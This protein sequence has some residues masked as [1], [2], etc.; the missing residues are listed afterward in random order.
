ME[1]AV[2]TKKAVKTTTDT[3]RCLGY[4]RVS[5]LDQRETGLSVDVQQSMILE[6][7]GEMGGDL[8]EDV[9]IDD[10][11]SGTNMNRPGLTALLAR[12]SECDIDYLIFQDSSRLSRD[13][14]DY[15]TI[16]TVLNKYKIE[17]IALTGISS[18]DDDPYSKFFDEILASVNALHPR[19]SGYKAK[20][21]QVEK[22]KS[23]WYPSWA[24]IGYKNIKNP[25]PTSRYDQKIIALD[26]EKAPFI[27]Q[28]FLMYASQEHT[29]Y[30]IRQ[31]FHKN[32][33]RGQSGRQVSYSL[34]HNILKN[35]FYYGLMRWAD[36]ESMGLHEPLIN[37]KTFD[38]VQHILSRRSESGTRTRKH[39]F[40][41]RGVVYCNKCEKRYTA[42]WHVNAKKYAKRGGKIGYYHCS[43]VGRVYKCDSPYVEL[44]ELE[45][46]VEQEVEK[47]EFTQEFVEAVKRNVQEVYEE[48][49]KRV[50]H[51]RKA[52]YNRRDALEI[53][54]EKLEEELLAGTITRDRFKTLNAKID[55]DMVTVQKE[56]ADVNKIK[57]IDV[58]IVDEVLA[59]TRDIASTYKTA[60]TDAKRAYLRFFIDRIYVEDKKIVRI[61]YKPV[62]EVLN[63][64]KL[65]IL[66]I[67]WLAKW[68]DFGR[69]DWYDGLDC[70]EVVLLE[71]RSLLEVT[72]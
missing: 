24:P 26:P 56:L 10:G 18:F 33:I 31:Y 19:I 5:T 23:G 47:L 29:I 38:K 16:R 55:A 69:I 28:A 50:K 37:K 30:S 36:M 7:V 35:P 9:Y 14:R 62:I 63:R 52:A 1:I 15:L 51:A 54:R 45:K 39:N 34:V 25:S 6:K 12:C 11:R 53:K 72:K 71:A 48:S 57:A 49:N 46:Q 61:E 43:G 32:G 21:T 66:S 60:S 20:Q 2:D 70:P 41:L 44:E 67:N 4:A 22:F 42:E 17:L 59:L 13:T 27:K 64:A 8:V 65:G 58:S 3:P 68:D 40:L